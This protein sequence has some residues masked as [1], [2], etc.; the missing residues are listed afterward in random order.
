M[1]SFDMHTGMAAAVSGPDVMQAQADVRAAALAAAE[2]LS[3]VEI[4]INAVSLM[5]PLTGIGQYTLQLVRQLQMLELAPWLFYGTGWNREI[6]TGALPGIGT[7]KNLF[8][9]IVPRP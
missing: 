6:R 7:A 1:T 8:K 4:G 2:A 3:G 5:S 9:R